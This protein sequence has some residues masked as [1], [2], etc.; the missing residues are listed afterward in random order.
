MVKG[1]T[2]DVRSSAL[3]EQW[4]D[5]GFLGMG[6][7]WGWIW[8]CYSGVDAMRFFPEGIQGSLVYQMYLFST[9]GI[10]ASVLLCALFWKRITPLIDSRGIVLAFGA[11]AG[12]AT[13]FMGFS[14]LADSTAL[15]VVAAVFT[16]VG[17]SFLCLKTGRV[18]G[19][20]PLAESLTAGGLSL[21]LATALYFVGSGLPQEWRLI[22]IALLPLFSAVLFS[23]VRSDEQCEADA[24]PARVTTKAE[25]GMFGRLVMAAAIVAFTAGVGKGIVSTVDVGQ[26]A[27]EGALCVFAIAAIAIGIIA[28]VNTGS[29]HQHVRAVYSGLMVLGITVMLASCFG[30]SVSYLTVGKEALWLIFSCLM[31]YLAFKFE[32]SSVRVFGIGQAAY[33]IASII[34]W[35]V[36]T[37][38]APYYGETMVRMAVGIGQAF[39]AV[40]IMVYIFPDNSIKRIATWKIAC[41]VDSLVSSA[42]QGLRG[43]AP[44]GAASVDFQASRAHGEEIVRAVDDGLGMQATASEEGASAAGDAEADGGEPIAYGIH[45]AED[46]RYGL[47][48][49]EL[50]ILDLFAQGRSANWIADALVISKN[51]VR[52]H[53]R[54]IYVKLDVHTRQE[55]LDFLSGE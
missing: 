41:P 47:S 50:E 28:A 51:T 13:L 49:R 7:W 42:A 30:L 9:L 4:P 46:P 39:L 53:L 16:G 23:L 38:V 1:I 48:R 29:V 45:R 8:L 35:I 12:V 40:L 11:F 22:Y 27:Y 19:S 15:F 55:L 43:S 17:T 31:A 21:L 2:K 44:Q 32:M 14:A 33:F 54:A 26:F 6:A 20:V 3:M 24:R 18:Y 5:I 36:G 34:G 25:K 10:A 37:C 52:S